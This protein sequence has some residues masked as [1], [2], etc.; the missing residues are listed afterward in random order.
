MKA[1]Q[2]RQ[3]TNS[4]NKETLMKELF[5]IIDG[6]SKQGLSRVLI[7]KDLPFDCVGEL[8]SL[9]YNVCKGEDQIGMSYHKITW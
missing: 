3:Q 1:S 5:Q 9:G 2:A 4:I 6:N 7:F 8:M